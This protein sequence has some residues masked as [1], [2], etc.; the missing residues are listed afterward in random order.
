MAATVVKMP[1]GCSVLA[2][3]AGGQPPAPA[4]DIGGTARGHFSSWCFGDCGVSS[5]NQETESLPLPPLL[6][7]TAQICGATRVEVF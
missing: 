7:G 4:L 1:S 6:G 3:W 5:K 2:R